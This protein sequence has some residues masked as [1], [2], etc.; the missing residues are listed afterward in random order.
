V[1][2]RDFLLIFACQRD[3]ALEESLVLSQLY[4]YKEINSAIGEQQKEVRSYAD[5]CALVHQISLSCTFICRCSPFIYLCYLLASMFR[6][7]S[8]RVDDE[9]VRRVG[10]DDERIFPQAATTTEALGMQRNSRV[11]MQ[12]RLPVS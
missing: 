12:C 1:S 6:S 8:A 9:E 7:A 5:T 2:I 10:G 4:T 3:S 11:L